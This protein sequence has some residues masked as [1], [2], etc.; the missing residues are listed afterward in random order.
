MMLAYLALLFVAMAMFMPWSV[1][2][3]AIWLATGLAAVLS[4]VFTP[5]GDLPTPSSART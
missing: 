2:A 4:L 1:R 3:H 5:L